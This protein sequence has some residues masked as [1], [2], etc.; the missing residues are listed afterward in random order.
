M[1][2]AYRYRLKDEVHRARHPKPISRPDATP[3]VV[4]LLDLKEVLSLFLAVR[5]GA[6][7]LPLMRATVQHPAPAKSFTTRICVGRR[8]AVAKSSLYDPSAA[9]P[10]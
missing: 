1:K 8:R 9:G 4:R 5:D 7:N 2:T 6:K 3:S 10:L